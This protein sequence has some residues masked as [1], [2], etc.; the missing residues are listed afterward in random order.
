MKSALQDWVMEL[1][2]MQ[3]SVLMAAIRNEDGVEK[4]HKQKPL[5]R[6]YRRC[7]LLSA[8]DG[9][10]LTDPQA[11]GGGEFTGPVDDINTAL[12]DFIRSRDRMS[13]HYYAH[14]MHAFE[15]LGYNHP[16]LPIRDFWNWAYHRMVHAL[17]LWEEQPKE[18]ELR[19]GDNPD[20]WKARNDK[21]GCCSS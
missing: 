15:I 12:D 13:L 20:T 21:A 10:A 7:V 6:W 16:V 3:Q 19:L 11:P 5:I 1:P 2:I 8:F 4:G 18:L 14:A 9:V 17:H